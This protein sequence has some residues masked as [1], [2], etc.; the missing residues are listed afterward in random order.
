MTVPDYGFEYEFISP[1]VDQ[2]EGKA[3][4]LAPAPKDKEIAEDVDQD[5]EEEQEYQFR[6]FTS[7]ATQPKA[8]SPTFIKPI[9]RLSR[10]PSPVVGLDRALSL[11]KAHFIRPNRPD[12]YYFTAALPAETVHSL[13]SQYAQVAV[14]TSDVIS[15]AKATSWPGTTLPWRVIHV[16]L[17]NRSSSARDRHVVEAIVKTTHESSSSKSNSKPKAKSSK[18]RR[19]VLRRRLAKSAELAAQAVEAELT[20]KE[21]R[22]RRNREKKV[23]RKE[24]EKKKKLLDGTGAAQED[25]GL[26]DHEAKGS[27][28]A[29]EEH[30]GTVEAVLADRTDES[31]ATEAVREGKSRQEQ[32]EEKRPLRAPS[33]EQEPTPTPTAVRTTSAPTRRAPTS[34]SRVPT[35]ARPS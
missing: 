12:T 3:R 10:S 32:D 19:I 23:K 27:N 11:D 29:G 34:K 21:K 25:G 26:R 13:R 1:D 2:A 33:A 15:R 28:P 31:R 7:A 24:R 20:E 16:Q 14:S 35:S 22:T 30:K 4:P 9:I 5:Q 8:Q 17:A 18:K 6:L